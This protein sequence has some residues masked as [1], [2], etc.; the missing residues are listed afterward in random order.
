M[1]MTV[2]FATSVMGFV[3]HVHPSTIVLHVSWGTFMTVFV[4]AHVP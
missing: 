3:L 1:Q 2:G 4:I